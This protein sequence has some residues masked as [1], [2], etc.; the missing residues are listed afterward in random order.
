MTKKQ[1]QDSINK[2]LSEKKNQKKIAVD[3]EQYLEAQK[4]MESIAALE[5]ELESVAL[6]SDEKSVEEQI[7]ELKA[8]KQKLV[9][10][11]NF[12][13]ADA[14]K[15]KIME[16]HQQMQGVGGA[17]AYDQG[18]KRE[19]LIYVTLD[20]D[21]EQWNAGKND[22][23]IKQLKKEVQGMSG[24]GADAITIPSHH[25]DLK[26]ATKGKV[27]LDVIFKIPQSFPEKTQLAIEDSLKTMASRAAGGALYL[28]DL[29]VL[30]FTEPGPP[31]PP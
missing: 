22:L 17:D 23:I 11:E 27:T 31:P 30:L 18:E 12:L 20:T 9:A 14:I 2:Q 1:Q 19:T 5:K 15:A 13:G 24:M 4:I 7:E 16:L 25:P 3:N 26:E 6:M 28:G 10:E 29:K 21:A 8:E